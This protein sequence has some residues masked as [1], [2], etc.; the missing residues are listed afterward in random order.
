MDH[1]LPLS[2]AVIAGLCGFYDEIAGVHP[3]TP[4]SE[5]SPPHLLHLIHPDI[6]YAASG[7]R[8]RMPSGRARAVLYRLLVSAISFLMTDARSPESKGFLRTAA[9]GNRACSS[10]VR[11]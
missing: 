6:Q 2:D 4:P 9:C 5:V 11:P 1:D 3:G 10:A 8:V 7:P